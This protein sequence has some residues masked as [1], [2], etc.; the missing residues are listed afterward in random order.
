VDPYL[1]Y[2]LSWVCRDHRIFTYTG[3]SNHPLLIADISGISKVVLT[4]D[5]FVTLLKR[6]KRGSLVDGAGYTF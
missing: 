3:V 6:N 4:E 2:I 1:S 5:M